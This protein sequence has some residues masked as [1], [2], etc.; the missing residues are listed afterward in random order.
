MVHQRSD[1]CAYWNAR[2]FH[3]ACLRR[4]IDSKIAEDYYLNYLNLVR[5]EASWEAEAATSKKIRSSKAYRLG[6]TLLR[7][8]SWLKNKKR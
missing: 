1:E 2:V 8:F 3:E 5:E 6:K 7:P 4:G